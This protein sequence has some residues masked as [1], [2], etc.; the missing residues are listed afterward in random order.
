MK[1][2]YTI[3]FERVYIYAKNEMEVEK[4]SKKNI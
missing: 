2:Q 1:R 4:T 3:T